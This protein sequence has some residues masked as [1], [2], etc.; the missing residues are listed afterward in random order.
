[1]NVRHWYKEKY[2]LELADTIRE[3]EELESHDGEVK[4]SL[5]KGL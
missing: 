1:M 4:E 2:E 5:V 3:E